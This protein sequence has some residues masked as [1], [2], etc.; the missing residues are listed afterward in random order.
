MS[1]VWDGYKSVSLSSSSAT[2][3]KKEEAGTEAAPPTTTQMVQRAVNAAR[4]A[5]QRLKKTLEEIDSSQRKWQIYQKQLRE[6]FL[7]QQE[8]FNKDLEALELEAAKQQEAAGAAEVRLK[9]VLDGDVASNRKDAVM[10]HSDVDEMDPWEQLISRPP[11]VSKQIDEDRRLAQMFQQMSAA[12]QHAPMPSETCGALTPNSRTK[13]GLPV[14]PNMGKGSAKMSA[15]TT[16]AT[17]A[18]R[19]FYVATQGGTAVQDPYQSSPS[20]SLAATLDAKGGEALSGRTLTTSPTTRTPPTGRG[21]KQSTPIKD[22]NKQPPPR[23]SGASAARDAQL[24]AKREQAMLQAM[25]P[26]A[27][28]PQNIAIFDD[29]DDELATVGPAGNKD[30]ELQCME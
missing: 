17:A 25:G 26:A 24:K 29:D 16:T 15:M 22:V 10:D 2:P 7:Q 27:V 19:P 14:T 5:D 18:L 13:G 12:G 23:E 4:R 21:G 8:Q 20:Q 1:T 11:V 9:A 28:V 30:A 3:V 6:L